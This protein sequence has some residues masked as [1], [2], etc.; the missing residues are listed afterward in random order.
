MLCQPHE[1]EK[2]KRKA[3]LQQRVRDFKPPNLSMVRA[4]L[5]WLKNNPVSGQI[6]SRVAEHKG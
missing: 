3:L 4:S 1:E 6:S 5:T 2:K